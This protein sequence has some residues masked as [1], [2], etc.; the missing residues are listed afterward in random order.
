[1]DLVEEKVLFVLLRYW[2]STSG[3]RI[4]IHKKS[5]SAAQTCSIFENTAKHVELATFR[6][7]VS[8]K[9]IKKVQIHFV[10]ILDSYKYEM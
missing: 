8:R 4:L 1:M 10:L 6:K 9:R 3:T 2:T 5:I 7:T